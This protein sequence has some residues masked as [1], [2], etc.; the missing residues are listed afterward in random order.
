MKKADKT[1]CLFSILLII[2]YIILMIFPTPIT[3]VLFITYAIT[4]GLTG[5]YTIQH[6]KDKEAKP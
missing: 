3:G 6:M 2:G 4:C 1:A 5:G